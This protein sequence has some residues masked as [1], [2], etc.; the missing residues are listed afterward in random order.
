M[1]EFP[2]IPTVAESGVPGFELKNTYCL[3]VLSKTPAALVEGFNR[4]IVQI[5]SAPEI[6]EKYAVDSSDVAPPYKPEELR[7]IMLAEFSKWEGI[8]RIA[9]IKAD[10][11]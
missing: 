5:L 10:S 7:R 4:Q 6:R 9:N 3:Y 2:D 1:P 11:P 8:A